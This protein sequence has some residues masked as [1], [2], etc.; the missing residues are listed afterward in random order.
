MTLAEIYFDNAATTKAAPEAAEAA[1]TMLT[2][3]FGNPSSLHFK[4]S[5]AYQA[6]Q[7]ARYQAASI[8]GASTERVF[9]TSGG[10]ASNNLAVLGACATFIGQGKSMVT[11]AVEHA[12]LLGAAEKL[13]A[14]GFGLTEILPGKDGVIRPE[15]VIDAVN[16]NTVLVSV[17]AV[18]NETGEI[19]PLKDIVRGVRA[20]NKDTLIHTDAVQ[21]FG[22]LPLSLYEYPVDLLSISGHKIHGAKGAGGLYIKEGVTVAPLLFGGAQEGRISPGTEN[23]AAICAFGAACELAKADREESFSHVSGLKNTIFDGL[24][25]LPGV[26]MNSPTNSSPYILNISTPVPTDIMVSSLSRRRIYVSGSSAC[27]RGAVSRPV[28]LMGIEGRRLAGV[29]RIGLSR[30]NT[31]E[32]AFVLLSAIEEIIR[33]YQKQN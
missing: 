6:I 20:K 7:R 16:Q 27:A 19:L 8:L 29:L 21:A 30:Y 23:T 26:F 14:Q 5:E 33:D 9:F 25:S 3:S 12:S 22:K 31:M 11:T 18:N 1:F 24:S 10:T 15:D 4:G 17:M 32:E 28:R 13:K 2:S